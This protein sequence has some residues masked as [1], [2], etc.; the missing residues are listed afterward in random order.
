[1]KKNRRSRITHGEEVNYWQSYSDL[2]TALLLMFMLITLAISL[3]ANSDYQKDIDKRVAY[4]AELEEQKKRLEENEI[5]RQE[6]ERI[7]KEQEKKINDLIGI[8]AQIIEDLS[9]AFSDVDLTVQIDNNTGS[10]TF[11]SSVLFD[12]N[13]DQI[14]A[15]G[16]QFLD[17]FL[18]IYVNSILNEK[19]KDY[20]SEIIVE[21][22]TDDK[23]EF[24]YNLE[25]SQKRAFSVSKYCLEHPQLFDEAIDFEHL[26]AI[27]T[28][29]GKSMNNLITDDNGKVNA[30][31]SRRVEFK[32]RLKDDEMINE[33]RNILEN[34]N[35]E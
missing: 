14:K 28:T 30:E 34:K 5:R 6:D 21:G 11:A 9:Q 4:E 18:P 8:K 12:Y 1:M 19:F 32:F 16:K 7:M 20:I 23:G 15:T 27:L 31:A 2:M 29:N 33:M 22:Y 13:S 26:K 25:L 17:E 35:A 10:I 24:I 3:K